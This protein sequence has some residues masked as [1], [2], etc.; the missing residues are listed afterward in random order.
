[1]HAA[2][3]RRRG[4]TH[5]LR[6]AVRCRRA[7]RSVPYPLPLSPSVAYAVPSPLNVPNAV[8][9]VR[10]AFRVLPAFTACL[11]A[12]TLRTTAPLCRTLPSRLRIPAT[13]TLLLSC[14]HYTLTRMVCDVPSPSLPPVLRHRLLHVAC[15]FFYNALS[16]AAF[17][18][19]Y[20]TP[21]THHYLP[22]CATRATLRNACCSICACLDVA[23]PHT[24][25]LLWMVAM[26]TRM[27]RVLVSF[28]PCFHCHNLTCSLPSNDL[29]ATTG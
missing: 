29:R 15:T 1:M 19:A 26:P 16:T 4:Q 6:H 2:G 23:S 5:D 7:P 22:A 14:R 9:S 3:W 13:F 10:A 25:R 18:M 20:D 17:G 24:K 21:P 11:Y 8:C 12:R 27:A 28:T